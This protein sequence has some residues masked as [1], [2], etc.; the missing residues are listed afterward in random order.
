[1][2]NIKRT[3]IVI[4]CFL[5]AAEAFVIVKQN[6]SIH[7]QV[8]QIKQQE[9]TIVQ[10]EANQNAEYKLD[11]CPMC[12]GNAVM[13]TINDSFYIICEDCELQTDYFNTKG[14]I[15]EYWNRRK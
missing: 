8:N 5:V 13:K 7:Q 11:S 10:L 2:K 9:E 12:G 15:A 6:K 3:L 14:E 4:V 1:M